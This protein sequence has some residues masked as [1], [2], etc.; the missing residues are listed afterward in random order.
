MLQ[1]TPLTGFLQPHQRSV[2]RRAVAVC[3]AEKARLG[4]I[5]AISRVTAA[6]V[7][8]MEGVTA[9][10]GGIKGLASSSRLHKSGA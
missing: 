8:L 3:E 10:E 6:P 9:P 5:V 1:K 7:V 2:G 4:V